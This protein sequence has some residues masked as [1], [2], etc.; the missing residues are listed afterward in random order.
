MPSS[1][2][3]PSQPLTTAMRAAAADGRE[4]A[5]PEERRVEDGVDTLGNNVAHRGREL[6]A[7]RQNDS[8]AEASDELLVLRA[9]V[10]EHAEPAVLRD[11]DHVGGEQARASGD[12]ER[13]ALDEAE[14]VEAVQR[15]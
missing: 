5:A 8:G 15:R 2:S 10:G 7:T 14:K 13:L 6:G 3:S 9:C 12:G 1:T 11:A 4:H